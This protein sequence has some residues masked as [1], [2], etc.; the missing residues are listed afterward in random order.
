MSTELL[1]VIR[2]RI[3]RYRQMAARATVEDAESIH[4]FRVASRELLAAAP[5][6]SRRKKGWVKRAKRELSALNRLRDLQVLHLRFADDKRL[7]PAI[8]QA[9]A[10]W[11]AGNQPW[12]A[13]LQRALDTDFAG[14]TLHAE[15]LPPQLA[16]LR[17]KAEKRLRRRLCQLDTLD[18]ATFHRLRLAWKRLR[19]LTLLAA[20]SEL[21]ARPDKAALKSWQEQL[22]AIQDAEVAADWLGDGDAGR[23]ES[24]RALLL[25]Q[26]LLATLP[27]LTQLLEELKK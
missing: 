15:Q 11:D 7:P 13:K 9:A 4:Q 22:G 23:E 18:P 19:Y 5:L 1:A 14:I 27:Q 21:I 6:L 3:E 2:R 10:A 17:R 26:Q 8:A 25:R 20:E 16:K 12:P 24:A